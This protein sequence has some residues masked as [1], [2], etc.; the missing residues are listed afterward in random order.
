ILAEK[1]EDYRSE[2]DEIKNALV[3]AQKLGDASVREA[4]HK[5]EI[6]VKDANLK[7]EHI[8][9]SAEDRISDQKRQLEE[10]KKQVSDF[11]SKLLDMY[12]QHLTLIDALP[13]AKKE[14]AP[15]EAQPPVLQERPEPEPAPAPPFALEQAPFAEKA[16]PDPDYVQ[17]PTLEF[18][19]GVSNFDDF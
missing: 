10:L 4:R 15:A 1:I 8:V 18:Q 13:T 16:A 3:S 5:A 6:I 19:A 9:A 14:A 12:R 7:A 11:R 17:E 2:E